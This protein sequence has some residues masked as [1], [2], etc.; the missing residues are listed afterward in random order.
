MTVVQDGLLAGQEG[1]LEGLGGHGVVAAAV[2]GAKEA[3]GGGGDFHR[4]RQAFRFTR[5]L[6]RGQP[7]AE[8]ADLVCQHGQD[9]C[10]L[11][12]DT[13]KSAGGG[14]AFLPQLME[15]F[16]ANLEEA[17]IA[18]RA[19]GEDEGMGGEGVPAGVEGTVNGR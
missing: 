14:P 18:Q 5:G 11:A 7:G 13:G 9:A 17:G 3:L 4:P 12:G 8:E 6:V 10:C 15:D 19:G 1:G 16:V 2:G